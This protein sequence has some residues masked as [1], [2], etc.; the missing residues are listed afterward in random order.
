MTEDIIKAITEAEEQAARIKSDALAE[1]AQILQDA[2]AEASRLE[3]FSAEEN[4][5]YREMQI[6]AANAQ[7]DKEYEF[8]LKEK[9]KEAKAYCENALL[10]SDASVGK[11]IGRILGGDR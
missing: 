5:Q 9:E 4:K 11:I 6:K 8:T 10:Q 7:A 1:A 3:K 2:Q